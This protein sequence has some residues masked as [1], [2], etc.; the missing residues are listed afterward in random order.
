MWSKIILIVVTGLVS[1]LTTWIGRIP[2]EDWI[3]AKMRRQY[4]GPNAPQIANTRWAAEWKYEDGSP[5]LNDIVTFSKWTK[6]NL[7]EGFGEITYPNKQY[8]Y[9]IKGEVS[10]R[11]V[12]VL[13][14]K[15]EGYPTEANIGTACLQLSGNAEDLAGTWTGLQGVKQS[16]GTE[17]FE[18]RGGKVAMH[19]IKDLGP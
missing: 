7:F 14:Y 8:K 15:A 9:S 5:S 18:L 16:N 1:I 11:G 4:L 10:P 12:V 2:V 13:N 6:D 19:K 17:V 3:S